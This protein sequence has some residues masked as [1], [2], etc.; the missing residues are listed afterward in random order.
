MG[1]RAE[2]LPLRGVPDGNELR[3]VGCRPAV[4]RAKD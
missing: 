4:N 3:I 1:M 2:S